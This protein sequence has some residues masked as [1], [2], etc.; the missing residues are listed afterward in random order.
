MAVCMHL[1]CMYIDPHG[2]KREKQNP[3]AQKSSERGKRVLSS[4]SSDLFVLL[5]EVHAI[6]QNVKELF[7]GRRT[8][9]QRFRFGAVQILQLFVKFRTESHESI[10]RGQNVQEGHDLAHKDAFHGSLI[11]VFFGEGCLVLTKNRKGLQPG[12]G[13]RR[14]FSPVLEV[15][16]NEGRPNEA[17][18]HLCGGN[19]RPTRE[20]LSQLQMKEGTGKRKQKGGAQAVVSAIAHRQHANASLGGL[21][22]QHL[23]K[24]RGP[25]SCPSRRRRMFSSA[26]AKTAV[27]RYIQLTFLCET[28]E[29]DENGH[30]HHRKRFFDGRNA[31]G[32]GTTPPLFLAGKR[33][34]AF[35]T[36][37]IQHI[38]NHLT[39]GKYKQVGKAHGSKTESFFFEKETVPRQMVVTQAPD[40]RGFRPRNWNALEF[41]EKASVVWLAQVGKTRLLL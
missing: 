7:L 13:T 35:S 4:F 37:S 32:T 6:M 16:G 36:T 9:M 27:R 1:S 3:S 41:G 10:E 17:S 20:V 39:H 19:G 29:H 5:Q 26:Y 8:R 28:G 30:G 31:L 22:L 40:K 2:E 12:P 24:Q 18:V 15:S 33:S 23:R 38:H 21:A 14:S 34:C 25:L 11:S